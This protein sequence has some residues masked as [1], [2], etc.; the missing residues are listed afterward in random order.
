MYFENNIVSHGVG[1]TI[2]ASNYK[3]PNAELM[4]NESFVK[5][6]MAEFGDL[7]FVGKSGRG[8]KFDVY[9]LVEANPPLI[10]V[11]PNAIKVTVDGPRPPRRNTFLK[12]LS[13]KNQKV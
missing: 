7:R 5:N 11:Y 8:T 3:N 9:I 2:R 4:N 13:F 12:N 10:I 6:G 1:V